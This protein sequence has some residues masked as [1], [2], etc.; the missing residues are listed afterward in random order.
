MEYE[1]FESTLDIEIQRCNL[2]SERKTECILEALF[3]LAVRQKEQISALARRVEGLERR[4]CEERD[5]CPPRRI[6]KA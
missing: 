4:L 3:E 5:L 1:A 6:R 2:E